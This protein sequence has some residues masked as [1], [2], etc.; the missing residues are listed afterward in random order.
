M[1]DMARYLDHDLL[2]H[3]VLSQSIVRQIQ[4]RTVDPELLALKA[5]FLD[6]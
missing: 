6:Q 2:R 3:I 5:D 1:V 4:S